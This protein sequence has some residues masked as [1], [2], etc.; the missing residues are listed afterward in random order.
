MWT[1]TTKAHY[2]IINSHYV[3]N[4]VLL[5]ESEELVRWREEDTEVIKTE[6]RMKIS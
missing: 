3:I 1:C 6:E 4:Y 5:F 2:R